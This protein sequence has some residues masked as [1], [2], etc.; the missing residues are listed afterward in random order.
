MYGKYNWLKLGTVGIKT[1]SFVC[2][3]D[4]FLMDHCQ[5]AVHFVDVTKDIHYAKMKY[6]TSGQLF[7]ATYFLL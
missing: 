3:F 6:K 5:I 7:S 2:S 1:A 4:E